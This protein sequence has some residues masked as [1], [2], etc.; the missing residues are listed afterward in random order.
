MYTDA[1][2]EPAAMEGGLGGVLVD[3]AGCVKQWF[4]LALSKSQCVCLGAKQKDTIIYGF[5]MTA[6]VI[7]T[8]L[9]CRDQTNDLHTHLGDNDSVRFSFKGGPANGAVA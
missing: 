7:A 8:P 1:S 4:G 5:E 3:S 2:Y 6:A 9:W